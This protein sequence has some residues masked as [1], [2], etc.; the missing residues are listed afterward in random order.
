MRSQDWFALGVR[1]F[2]VWLITRGAAY[3]ATWIDFRFGFSPRP[4]DVHSPTATG[5]LVYASVDFT[6]ALYFLLGA[7]HLAGLCYREDQSSAPP[8]ST[9]PPNQRTD[10]D[11]AREE[12]P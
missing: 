5:Y 9:A 7:Q 8:A 11:P 6:L 12:G 4:P 1:L 10:R 2:G 3:V